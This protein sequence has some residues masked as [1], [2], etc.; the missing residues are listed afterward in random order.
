MQ[1]VLA[2][3]PNNLTVLLKVLFAEEIY[4]IWM[5]FWI[6]ICFLLFYLRLASAR[7]FR[8]LVYCTIGLT[9]A[10]TVTIWLIYCLQCKPLQAFWYPTLYPTAKCLPSKVTYFVPGSLELFLDCI[11]LFLPVT[12]FWGLQMTWRRRLAVYSVITMGGIVVVV[13]GLR[14]IVVNQFATNPDFTY[15][16]GRMILI[17]A[18]EIQVGIFAANMPGIKAFY[19]IWR[20]GELSSNGTKKSQGSAGVVSSGQAHQL[21]TLWNKRSDKNKTVEDDKTTDGDGD[22]SERRLTRARSSEELST[23]GGKGTITV[24]TEYSVAEDEEYRRPRRH[25]HYHNTVPGNLK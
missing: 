3:D 16:L 1:E 18:V 12:V 24:A 10:I 6:K 20:K 11:I 19:T 5:H 22:G 4:Y 21:A 13:S 7:T 15:I 14:L 17:S 2:D 8:M 9:A 25:S 23:A